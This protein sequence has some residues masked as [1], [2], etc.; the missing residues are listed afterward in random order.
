MKISKSLFGFIMFIQTLS[1]EITP[2]EL[3]FI[4]EAV[5]ACFSEV[6]TE[7][8]SIAR[9]DGGHSGDRIFFLR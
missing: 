5:K 2:S 1:A 6:Q 3:R 8:L 9:L 4:D 7:N